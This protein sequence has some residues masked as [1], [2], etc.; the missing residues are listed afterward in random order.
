MRAS[1]FISERLNFRGRITVAATA[2]SFF[3][4]ILSL[5]V[6]GGVK[7]EIR[8]GISSLMGDVQMTAYSL[9]YYV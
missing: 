8:R 9:R 3:V 2:V 6:L 7:R 1:R 4:I 5:M